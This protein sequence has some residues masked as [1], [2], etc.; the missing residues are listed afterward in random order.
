MNNTLLR[1]HNN[2]F[3][4]SSMVWQRQARVPPPQLLHHQPQ[5]QESHTSRPGGKGW[6]TNTHTGLTGLQ[7]RHTGATPTAIRAAPRVPLSNIKPRACAL[8][9]CGSGLCGGLGVCLHVPMSHTLP[10]RQLCNPPLSA[11]EQVARPHPGCKIA[12][13]LQSSCRS[14]GCASP[15][16]L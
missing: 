12:S 9:L 11:T 5:V 8:Q 7:T 3:P 4:T 10:S 1:F 15:R 16:I 13:D 6:V 2:P 14:N